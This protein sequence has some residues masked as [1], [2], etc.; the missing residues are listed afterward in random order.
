MAAGWNKGKRWPAEVKQHISEGMIRCDHPMRGKVVPEA[1]RQQ[2]R[3]A[4]ERWIKKG[5]HRVDC[6]CM[7]CC[8]ETRRKLM[9]TLGNKKRMRESKRVG[10]K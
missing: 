5:I 8:V 7:H 1:R 9:E 3:E 4:L 2:M 10:Y 6:R